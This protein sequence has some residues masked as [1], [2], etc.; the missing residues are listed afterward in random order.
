M[1]TQYELNKANIGILLSKIAFDVTNGEIKYGTELEFKTNISEKNEDLIA[2]IGSY[3]YHDLYTFKFEIKDTLD[4]NYND[5]FVKELWEI[6]NK[7]NPP[8]LNENWIV[9]KAVK[10][11]DVIQAH[12]GFV[13]RRFYRDSI[14]LDT[15]YEDIK[16]GSLI[17][18]FDN[19]GFQFKK[20]SEW[21]YFYGKLY[22]NDVDDVIRFYFNIDSQPFLVE[23]QPKYEKLLQF[24][25][26]LAL[27]FNERKISFNFKLFFKQIK[28]NRADSIVLYVEKRSLLSALKILDTLYNTIDICLRDQTPMFTYKIRR[29]VGFAEEPSDANNNNSFGQSRI[30]Y[31]TTIVVEYLKNNKKSPTTDEVIAAIK[32]EYD[33]ES[34]HLRPQSVLPKTVELGKIVN[35][36]QDSLTTWKLD[37]SYLN[38]AENIANQLANQAI[39]NKADNKCTWVYAV[40]NKDSIRSATCNSSLFDGLCGIANFYIQLCIYK[41]DSLYMEIRDGVLKNLLSTKITPNDVLFTKDYYAGYSGIYSILSSVRP[42]TD[43]DN[44]LPP[45]VEKM[46]DEIGKILEK[47]LKKYL[48]TVNA[49]LIDEEID[50]IVGILKCIKP[51]FD[52]KLKL[53]KKLVLALKDAKNTTKI[54]FCLS[55]LNYISISNG[56]DLVKYNKIIVSKLVEENLSI[57]I[58]TTNQ[59]IQLLEYRLQIFEYLIPSGGD[60]EIIKLLEIDVLLRFFTSK[61]LLIDKNEINNCCYMIYNEDEQTY[62]YGLLGFLEIICLINKLVKKQ[63]LNETF[64]FDEPQRIAD[65][66]IEK[67]MKFGHFPP[68]KFGHNFYNPG[69]YDGLAGVG[70]FLLQLHDSATPSLKFT[71]AS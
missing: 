70:Y 56:S 16:Q 22:P 65:F 5:V 32:K 9:D 7:V 20:D 62:E 69:L 3:W 61:Y 54:V 41:P 21:V 11:S 23:K 59:N 4:E 42:F 71:N 19:S 50:I 48:G 17:N 31:I 8:T 34:F 13:N 24:V 37:N 26:K 52:T 49:A 14:T 36:S 44:I 35:F 57:N 1:M 28:Y 27:N 47:K 51:D 2:N 66:I 30:N 60:S 64:R 6:S 53:I 40:L 63:Y 10:N 15:P 25:H 33:F 38:Y 67:Y 46:S 18:I 68:A 45:L 12:K 39:W 29:G 55:K 58:F 43:F